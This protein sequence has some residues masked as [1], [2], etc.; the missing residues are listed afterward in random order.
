[1][2]K[3]IGINEKREALVLLEFFL[4]KIIMHKRI[5]FNFL[6]VINLSC[7][8]V[9]FPYPAWPKDKENSPEAELFQIP[10]QET[11]KLDGK[12]TEP[13]SSLPVDFRISD[14]NRNWFETHGVFRPQLNQFLIKI[15][16][17]WR[18]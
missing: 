14:R 10:V 7:L 8:L 3:A 6:F 16:Y 4:K 1:M 15:Q 12:L 5:A 2:L 17:A 18:S 13:T 11:I 9:F